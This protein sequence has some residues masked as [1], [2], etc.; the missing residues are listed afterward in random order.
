VENY[1]DE[2]DDEVDSDDSGKVWRQ[3][4]CHFLY[5]E[6]WEILIFVPSFCFHNMLLYVIY[7]YL[8]VYGNL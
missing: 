5:K 6:N 1:K 3:I 8:K 7:R 2:G 4:F